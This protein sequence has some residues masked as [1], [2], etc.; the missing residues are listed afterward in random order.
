[1]NPTKQTGQAEMSVMVRLE[2]SFNLAQA[3]LDSQ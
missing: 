2:L 1:M 3:V